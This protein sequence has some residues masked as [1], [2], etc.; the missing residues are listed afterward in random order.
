MKGQPRGG[1]PEVQ[2]IAGGAALE[3]A[4]GIL[5]EIGGKGSTAT[6]ADWVQRTDAAYLATAPLRRLEFQQ[7]QHLGHC[8]GFTHS[9]E[10]DAWHLSPCE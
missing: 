7:I 6:C 9:F 2:L 3:A 1:G 5:L 8:D 10:I 4:I